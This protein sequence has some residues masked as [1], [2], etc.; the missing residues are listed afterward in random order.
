MKKTIVILCLVIIGSSDCFSQQKS[1]DSILPL[2]TTQKDSVT[3]DKAMKFFERMWRQE[4][5]EVALSYEQKLLAVSS[6]IQYDKG[7]GNT[8][9]HIG[10]IHNLTQQHIKA[11]YNY[12][13][14]AT[15]FEKANYQRGLAIIHNNKS[16]IEQGRG[17]S[18]KAIDHIL[19]AN[20]YFERI[21]DSLVLSSL[22]NNLANIY[23]DI[24]NYELAEEYYKKSIVLKKKFRPNKIG[25]ALNNLA[26]IYIDI[27]KIDEA[28][29]LINEAL[30]VSKKNNRTLDKAMAYTRLANLYKAN[31]EY[32]KSKKY[33]D[34]SYCNAVQA[35]NF[36]VAAN[37]KQ[38]LGEIAIKL[39]NYDEAENLL[40]EARKELLRLDI[41]PLL[42]TN[43]RNS[44]TLDSARN[45]FAS[46]FIW[47]KKY[48]QIADQTSINETTEK[49]SKAEVRF[50]SELEQL[51]LLE[52]KE[53]Q[54]L[55]TQGELFKY[56]IFTFISVGMLIMGAIFLF[57][58]IKTRKERKRYIAEL[59]ESNQVK[60]K[61][62]SI[63]SHDLKNEI[64]GLDGTLNLL[65]ENAI[66]KEE[67]EEI[68]PL[69][70]NRTHQTSIMLNN[71]LNWSKS[72]MNEL[73]AKP[74]TFNIK[75]VIQN[76][77]SFFEPKAARKNIQLNNQLDATLV[78]ADK[79]MFSIVSQNL[80]ANAIKFCKP[81][82]S[83]TLLSEEKEK[84]FEIYFQDTGVG[85]PK[86]NIKKLFSEDTFTTKGTQQ[87]AGTGLGLKICKEL[88]ELNQGEI[89]V[90]S[91]LG[92]G[93][94]FCITL[95][96][97]S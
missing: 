37:I 5:Y 78:Y 69:L 44:A 16:T 88:V 93:S 90:K 26:L 6:N 1:L 83:I 12:D 70:S 23:S 54:E 29:K 31:K 61:L 49:I 33:Y 64:H 7:I 18:E 73:N 25:S 36:R 75:D 13:K 82:D 45:N 47:Q 62:F 15:Y 94:T 91:I 3:F 14:A 87:E 96:K 58:I 81:G 80:L 38:Q 63:I 56:R 79:D 76:K 89:K 50:K 4:E 41:P 17:N 67:F 30:E 39:K 11:F 60:N 28:K 77:F 27:G 2:I 85:I 43:Y 65:K 74:T 10:N 52:E 22:Y 8:Y 59:N 9:Q 20:L 48:Q 46:A 95:P 24:D 34:S 42:L 32:E 51:K 57:F 21:K 40:A 92:E 35:Q 84:H 72:Q 55:K 97:A 53:K 86:E 19:E 71:L 68:V 66:S